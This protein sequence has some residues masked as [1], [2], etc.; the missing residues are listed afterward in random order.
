MSES[1]RWFGDRSPAAFRPSV[2]MVDEGDQLRVSVELP[3]MLTEEIEIALGEESLIIAGNK[4][5]EATSREE[6]CFHTERAY[7]AFKRVLPLPVGVVRE[8]AEATYERGVLSVC[9]PKRGGETQR[10][11]SRL[12]C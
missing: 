12:V 3:G 10:A 1:K 9:I 11:R 6:G 5:V 8:A 7:G 4:R 2:D